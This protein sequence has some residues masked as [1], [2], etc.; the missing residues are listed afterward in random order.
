MKNLIVLAALIFGIQVVNAQSINATSDSTQMSAPT[1]STQAPTDTT[2]APA[3][4]ESSQATPDDG[5]VADEELEKYAVM[6][7]SVNDM[8]QT[9]LKDMTKMLKSNEKITNARY[10]ELS[11]IIDDQAALTKAK[12]KPEEI[13]FVKEV[14]TKKEEGTMRI[15]ETFQSMAKDFVGASSFNKI[16]KAL[17]SDEDVKKR[18]EA[19]MQKLG[20]SGSGN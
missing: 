15:Q 20:S 6:M 17:E 8:K 19:Q 1:D 7:D 3:P 2:Q 5:S 9:L 11:K 14:A 13:A 10:N 12:A 16:K 18:Y 4:A